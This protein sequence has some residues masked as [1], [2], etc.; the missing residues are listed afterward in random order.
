[1]RGMLVDTVTG[2]ERLLFDG[3]SSTAGELLEQALER[4][5]RLDQ[6][7]LLPTE[8]AL[9]RE[10]AWE[11]MFLLSYDG[12]QLMEAPG[13]LEPTPR[14]VLMLMTIL[15]QKAWRQFDGT[16]TLGRY[17]NGAI[18]HELK[19]AR[20]RLGRDKRLRRRLAELVSYDEVVHT[21]ELVHGQSS[22]S[23]EETRIHAELALKRLV[24]RTRLSEP[25]RALLN[26][27]LHEGLTPA[28]AT[29]RLGY[30]FA[31]WESLRRKLRR[32]A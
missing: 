31:V 7:G 11:F 2:E 9:A 15:R 16:E 18:R 28:D 12:Q 14:A 21:G 3:P 26:L 6:A 20:S 8:R 25:Q 22:A 17:L 19:R 24:D 4:V 13:R 5:H 1:M 29:A 32:V 10:L 30:K 23:V 27:M